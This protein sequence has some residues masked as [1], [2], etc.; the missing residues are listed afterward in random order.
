MGIGA[1]LSTTLAGFA[2][3]AFGGTVAFFGMAFI[4]AIGLV[5]VFTLMPETRP[6]ETQFAEARRARVALSQTA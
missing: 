1:A 4:A 5:M 2:F 6:N 3:D